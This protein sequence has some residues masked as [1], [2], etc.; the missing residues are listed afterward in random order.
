MKSH[1]ALIL[2]SY[3]HG[4]S[5]KLTINRDVGIDRL[6]GA[7]MQ[8]FHPDDEPEVIAGKLEMLAHG[9]RRLAAIQATPPAP[10][11]VVTADLPKELP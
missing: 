4:C 10:D 8:V 3:D 9:I 5:F 6:R 2:E 1:T 7:V 11:A